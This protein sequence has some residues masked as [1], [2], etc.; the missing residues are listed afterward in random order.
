MSKELKSCPFCG[1]TANC[2]IFAMNDTIKARVGCMSCGITIKER[3]SPELSLADLQKST[4]NLIEK[5]NTRQTNSTY[6][7][8]TDCTF[9]YHPHLDDLEITVPAGPDNIYVR[10]DRE[11]LK[12]KLTQCDVEH[13][14]AY[15]SAWVPSGDNVM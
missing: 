5:W 2:E 1:G 4:D 9:K 11:T 7:T 10:I 8:G 3:L 12:A 13:E 6:L 15:K 14:E